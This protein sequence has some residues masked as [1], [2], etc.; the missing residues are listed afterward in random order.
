MDDT[1]CRNCTDQSD[2]G[3]WSPTRIL[4]SL[5]DMSKNGSLD[6]FEPTQC[7]TEYATMIQANRRNLLL[8]TANENV[9]ARVNASGIPLGHPTNSLFN[10]THLYWFDSFYAEYGLDHYEAADSYR[11]ICSATNDTETPCSNQLE[12]VKRASQ[13]MM[14]D[15][16]VETN[17]ICQGWIWPVDYCLSEPAVPRC[18]LHFNTAIAIVVTILNLRKYS[19]PSSSNPQILN[20]DSKCGEQ[21]NSLS[22]KAVLMFYILKSTKEDPLMTMGDAVASFIDEP[23]STTENIGLL[24]IQDCKRGYKPGATTWQNPQWRWKD[25]TSVKRRTVTLL[26][27]GFPHC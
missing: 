18:K 22:V 9:D 7:L 3:G 13:W 15:G 23:D 14:T 4:E 17:P 27:Y 11:W 26:L 25:V 2:Y 21:T 12:Q 19:C 20:E 6:R 8:V 5:W 10:N 16:C 24:S 1:E